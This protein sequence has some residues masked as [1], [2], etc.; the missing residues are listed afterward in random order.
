MQERLT[1]G[2]WLRQRRRELDL[3]QEALAERAGCSSQMIRKIESGTARPSRQL[4]ELLVARL[5]VSTAD[6][7][8]FVQWARGGTAPAPPVPTPANGLANGATDGP[9][10]GTV[11]FLFTDGDG[12]MAAWAGHPAAQAA[13]L[14]QHD[15]LLRAAIAGAGG[16]VF[17]LA[18][19]ACAAAFAVAAD[20]LSAAV[21]QRALLAAAWPP[22]L[23]A[24]RVRIALHTGAASLHAGEYFGLP[25]NRAAR[26]L[27][28]GHGG[29]VLLSGATQELV[30]DHLPPGVELRDLGE[31]R[32]KDLI[33]P[34]R[35][36]Q[37]AAPDLP[38]DFPPLRTLDT[39]LNNLPRQATALIGREREA[40]AVAALLRRPDVTLVTLTGPGGT[41]KTRLALQVAAEVLED[42]AAGVWFVDLAAL[43]DP[44]MV[45]GAMAQALGVNEAPTEPLATVLQTHLRDRQVLLVLDNFEHVLAA[46]PGVD[47]LLRAAPGL[48]VLV[49]SRVPL[50]LYGEHEYSVPPLALPDR[51]TVPS[52]EWLTQYEAVRLFIDRAQAV[53]A[54]FAVTNENAPAV[55]EI[56]TRLDGLPLAIEL[57]AARVRLFPPQALLARLDQRLP[58]L[59][60][61]ARNLPGR[62]QTLRN[63]IAWSYDLL[64]ADEQALFRQLAVFAGGCTL[65]AAE[66]VVGGQGSGSG[67]RGSEED[68]QSSVLSPQ[69]SVL[70][71]LDGL[72]RHSLVQQVEDGDGAPRFEMLD[73]I[74]EYARERLVAEGEDGTLGQ[75]HAAYWLARVEEVA[76]QL[77]GPQAGA[78]RARLE[79]DHDNLRAALGW[80][81]THGDAAG[82]WRFVAAVWRF[83]LA[84]GYITEGRAHLARALALAVDGPG[85][86][87]AS[88]RRA[89]AQALMGAGTLASVQADQRAAQAAYE[90]SLALWRALDDQQGIARALHNLGGIAAGQG[91]PATAAARLAESLRLYEALGD[92]GGMASILGSLGDAALEQGDFA[93]ARTRYDES[94]AAWRALGN[95]EAVA[96]KLFDFAELAYLQGDYAGAHALCADGLARMRAQGVIKYVSYGLVLLGQAAYRLDDL[97]GAAAAFRESLLIARDLGDPRRIGRCLAG[98]GLVAAAQG[99]GERAARLLGA[100]AALYAALS[101]RR[102][103][104]WQAE[105]ERDL[106]VAQAATD[107]EQWAAAWA[108]GQALTVEQ[109]VAYAVE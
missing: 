31:H 55:A 18:G 73:T 103:A 74:R 79:A 108:A 37:V 62:H 45:V 17:R 81:I 23:G 82:A 64:D 59:T 100:N 12:S 98:L 72:V 89:R 32:L 20:A 90:E 99:A 84:R 16:T 43:T 97:A 57:A 25:L 22:A 2:D 34:E 68:T 85:G 75:E 105:H 80:L 70:D 67:G 69:S 47:A 76:P 30:R 7:P 51:R 5:D 36:F 54:E 26:L 104:L 15:A 66:R 106:A 96:A 1:F 94:M 29:Q 101:L 56:C 87:D 65:E 102:T 4:A 88:L 71:Q 92:R 91:D 77:G 109:A 58:L 3:T 44:N 6:Q 39:H 83:W 49:T 9:P 42:F 48:K 13:A 38:A 41:G 78:W 33:R 40:A 21:A 28:A 52:L 19:G 61:G 53:R 93:Q 60:G 27:A 10:T 50:Q 14:A 86:D 107:S 24:P 8:A 35:V 11:T 95:D 63:A 46:A